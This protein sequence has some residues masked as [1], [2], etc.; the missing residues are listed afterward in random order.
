[1]NFVYN[2]LLVPSYGVIGNARYI[3]NLNTGYFF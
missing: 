1:M 3:L 2:C